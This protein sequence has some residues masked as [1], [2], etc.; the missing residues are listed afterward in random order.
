MEISERISN[1]IATE[2]SIALLET[3]C[4][5]KLPL[6]FRQFLLTVNGGRP[7][8]RRF[9]FLENGKPTESVVDW[10]FG[11]CDDPDYGL[12]SNL[13]V[14]EGRIPQ[15]CLPVATDPFGNLILLSLRAHDYGTIYFWDHEREDP[16]DPSKDLQRVADNFEGFLGALS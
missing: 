9:S 14:Y 4:R 2:Q 7:V 15:S 12:V 16:N 5:G 6:Q 10:F 11:N 13:D 8:K 3:R 1:A